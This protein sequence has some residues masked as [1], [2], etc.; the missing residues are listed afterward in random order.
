MPEYSPERTIK[1]R[2]PMMADPQAPEECS[3][4]GVLEFQT[5]MG[6]TSCALCVTIRPVDDDKGRPGALTAT[7]AHVILDNLV[8][9][10]WPCMNGEWTCA[11][12]YLGYHRRYS[13][14]LASYSAMLLPTSCFSVWA[15]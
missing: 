13:F 8:R 15:D 11:A 2:M 7:T 12:F 4:S 10:R 14:G 9:T 1:P 6:E 3:G 5:M